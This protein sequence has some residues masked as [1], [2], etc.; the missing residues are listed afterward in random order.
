MSVFFSTLFFLNPEIM[1]LPTIHSGSGGG[2]S[3]HMFNESPDPD[4]HELDQDDIH[5]ENTEVDFTEYMWMENEEEFDKLEMKRLEE[6]A[7]AEGNNTVNSFQ[8]DW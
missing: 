3:F 6:E 5:S 8:I 1:K 4:D 2:N 7:L